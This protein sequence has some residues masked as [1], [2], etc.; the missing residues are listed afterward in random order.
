MKKIIILTN[1]GFSKRDYLRFGIEILK[2]EYSVEILDFTEL[3]EPNYWKVY[4]EKIF[5]CEGYKKI[6][7]TTNF[8]KI[9]STGDIVN[10]IDFLSPNAKSASI[11]NILKNKKIPITRVQNGFLETKRTFWEFLYKLFFLCID[12]NRLL[13]NI[14]QKLGNKFKNYQ[15][16]FSY[17][18]LVIGGE[19]ALEDDLAKKAKKII[20]SHSFD[21]DIFFKLKKEDI[22][23]NLKPYAVFLDQYLPFHS[24]PAIRGE[25]AIVSEEKYFPALN[26]FFK[27]FAAHP[28]SRYDLCTKY[29]YGRK[30]FL[31]KT[32]ELITNSKIVILHSSTS[33]SFAVLYEKPMVFITSNEIKRSFHDFRVHSYARSMN[34]LLFNIDKKNN[35]FKIPNSNKIFFHDKEKYQEYKD[36]YLKFP[37]S[38]DKYLWSIFL[39]NIKFY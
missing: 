25:K 18:Y 16:N 4:P 35:Y 19:A 29:L 20:K 37:K 27:D 8:M 11:K 21:Y 30:F 1:V 12:P 23:S 28:R 13:K 5:E 6:L 10:A 2:K 39:E 24:G 34:S 33:L 31:N 32:A 36:K 22:K 38:P 17:D 3:F 14:K 15:N 7:S 26:N 9:I